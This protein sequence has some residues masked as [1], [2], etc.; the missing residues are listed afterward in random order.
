MISTERKRTRRWARALALALGVVALGP[1][2]AAALDAD[3]A[4]NTA[5]EQINAARGGVGGIQQALQKAKQSE[6]SP[7]QRIADAVLLM[8]AKDYGRA[9]NVLNAIIEKYPDHPTA[10]P[11]ALSLLGE[12]YFQSKQYLS[13]RRVFR[14]IVSEVQNPRFAPYQEKALGRLVDVAMR[15]K[16][17]TEL[18]EVFDAINRMPPAA[19]GSGLAYA[20]GKAL[21]VRKDYAGAKAAF[22]SVDAKSSYAHQ[23]RYALGLIAV[24]EATPERFSSEVAQNP[25]EEP[26]PVAPERYAAAID[27]F[28]QVTRLPGD[29]AEHRHVIDLS[30]LAIGRL[31]YETD[32]WNQA[33]EAYNRV[34]RTSPEFSTMLYEL[35]WVYV[36]LGD[37]DRALRSLE[38]LAIA[39]PDSQNI[40]DGALLRGDLMLRAGQFKK[41]LTVYEGVRNRYEP[42]RQKVDD[43]L[44]STSDPAVYYDRL[45]SEELSALDPNASLPP[46]AI[47]WA[48][49]AEDGPKA[50]SIIDDVTEC[51][52]LIKESNEMIERLNA[53]LNSPNRVRAFP[54]LKAAMERAT[55]LLNRVGLARLAL[56]Q[57]MDD[58]D[59]AALGGEIGQARAQRRSL[60][61]RLRRIPVTD[62]D[63]ATRDRQATQQWNKASQGVQ[64]L[65]LQVD[66]LQ[67]IVNGLRRV[68]DEGAQHGVVRDPASIERFREEIVANERELELYR[69]Q[70]EALRKMVSAGRVQVGFGDQRFIEDDQVRRA[71]REALG[72][73]VALA[74]QGAG[75]GDL[76]AYARRI[77]PLLASADASDRAVETVVGELEAEVGRR[78]DG[79]K[80]DVAQETTNVVGYTVRLD[81]LDQQ[82]RL[83]VGEVAMR[84]F[85]LVR[86]RLKN[87]VLR[88]DVG[89]IEQAWEVREEQIT[90]VRA[91]QVERAREDRLLTEELQEVLDDSGDADE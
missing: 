63:F 47:Q 39:D 90:R 51:R 71:H 29:T 89:I 88:A 65:Q 15:T 12:T 80:K 73:E 20:R 50:F 79:V 34:G 13:A 27:Q 56:G 85:G 30:W 57:G 67:A 59:D 8:G 22:A 75:G 81:E 76:Q 28:N 91:L 6:R 37:V 44:G 77:Q 9:A 7:Q 58:V 18:D 17:F 45:S 66:Q 52:T 53:V 36:K 41:A 46:L 70:M 62:A 19:V 21:Y 38:V 42:M 55:S 64:R 43:F 5:N 2:P 54:E 31:L 82:A 74:A 83:V 61:A 11:D 3:E 10:Y 14:K 49:E 78:T 40:A 25:D 60:E 72:R 68:L 48:R 84:N 35:A 24:K 1:G 16:D 32:Q 69:K 33:V 23:A 4:V 87:V 86:D 26:P